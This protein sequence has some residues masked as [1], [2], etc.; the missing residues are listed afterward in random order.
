MEYL[1]SMLEG[2]A[3]LSHPAFFPCSLFI[4]PTSWEEATIKS[5]L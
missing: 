1:I 3:T 2:I 4:Y 5:G